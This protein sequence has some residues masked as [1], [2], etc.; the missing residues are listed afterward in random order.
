MLALFFT[1]ENVVL[2]NKEKYG[3]GHILGDLFLLTSGHPDAES[4][5]LN[6]TR[7]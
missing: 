4:L 5:T 6:I 1:T 2:I 3:S 7:T